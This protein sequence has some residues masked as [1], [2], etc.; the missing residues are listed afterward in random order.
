M[1]HYNI[2]FSGDFIMKSNTEGKEKG[3]IIYNNN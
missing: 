1:N 2:A 3:R